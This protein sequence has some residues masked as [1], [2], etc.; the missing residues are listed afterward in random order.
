MLS[1]HA[2]RGELLRWLSGFSHPPQHVFVVHGE[3]EA[4]EALRERIQRE[5]DWPVSVPRQN[6][7]FPL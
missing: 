2:D 6:Q 3:A 7:E 4:S 1:A 5:L